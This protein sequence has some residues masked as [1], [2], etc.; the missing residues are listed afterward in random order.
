MYVHQSPMEH[1]ILFELVTPLSDSA[2]FSTFLA[3]VNA[4]LT[5]VCLLPSFLKLVPL[6]HLV[7]TSL[8]P[9][10]CSSDTEMTILNIQTFLPISLNHH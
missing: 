10:N 7:S 9:V 3:V 5:A 2:I 4:F 1:Y 8:L 6:F